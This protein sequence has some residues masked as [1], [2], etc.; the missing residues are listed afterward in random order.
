MSGMG[1]EWK[2]AGLTGM[3]RKGACDEAIRGGTV[4]ELSRRCSFRL[5]QA[6]KGEGGADDCTT[7]RPPG[8]GG[9][10]SGKVG[11]GWGR[12]SGLPGTPR[13]YHLGAGG[14]RGS[15]GVGR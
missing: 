5:A 13:A 6:R 15:R 7:A 2:D 4:I 12:T 1:A 14:G 9:A 3:A 10:F 11:G 8:K